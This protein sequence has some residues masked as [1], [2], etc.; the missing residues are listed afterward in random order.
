ME[1]QKP[2][3][4]LLPVLILYLLASGSVLENVSVIGGTLMI[5]VGL[6]MFSYAY[7]KHKSDLKHSFQAINQPLH[8]FICN[9]YIPFLLKHWMAVLLILVVA[10]IISTLYIGKVSNKA[11]QLGHTSAAFELCSTLR[12][13]STI[14]APLRCAG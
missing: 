10:G 3:K 11:V 13:A 14:Q 9:L 8:E 7:L 2:S 4:A 12:Y 6:I 5:V 1:S